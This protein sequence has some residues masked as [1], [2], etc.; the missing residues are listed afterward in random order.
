MPRLP[1]FPCVAA[2]LGLLLC[3]GLAWAQPRLLSSL[4]ADRAEVAPLVRMELRFAEKLLV[5]RSDAHLTM[6]SMP[7]MQR[8]P[9]M[10]MAVSL[11]VQ[12]D[13][14]TLVVTADQPLPRGSYRLD[15]RAVSARHK[16]TQGRLHFTVQ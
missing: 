4:P 2:G 10:G 3:S 11:A 1:L 14:R 5:R 9:E 6:T 13:A 7:G 8:H 16:L 15:W 12:D